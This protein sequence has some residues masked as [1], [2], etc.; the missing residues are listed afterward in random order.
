MVI[1]GN[2]HVAM[3]KQTSLQTKDPFTLNRTT[4][5]DNIFVSTVREVILFTISF[6]DD[7]VDV[8]CKNLQQLSDLYYKYVK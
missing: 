4:L 1:T 8:A 5:H 2:L 7:D 6:K 3:T